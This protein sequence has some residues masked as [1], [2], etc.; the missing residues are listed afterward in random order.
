MTARTIGRVAA[1]VLLVLCT[2]SGIGLAV[3]TATESVAVSMPDLLPDHSTADLGDSPVARTDV[4][5]YR[6]AV[7]GQT[8]AI[9]AQA[10]LSHDP[11]VLFPAGPP[12][13]WTAEAESGTIAAPY[14]VPSGVDRSEVSVV[15]ANPYG[16]SAMTP[17]PFATSGHTARWIIAIALLV[18]GLAG[19]VIIRW[20]VGRTSTPG[21]PRVQVGH[22]VP[23]MADSGGRRG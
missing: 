20:V 7:P 5:H 6:D 23:A 8:Y 13:L 1:W 17:V 12:V 2:A 11:T 3:S 4:I 22:P 10:F 15:E 16:A 18:A 19:F 14:P 21:S 9:R